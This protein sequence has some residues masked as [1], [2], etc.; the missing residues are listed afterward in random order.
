[1]IGV[2]EFPRRDPADFHIEGMAFPEIHGERVAAESFGDFLSGADVFSLGRSPVMFREFVG[3]NF[4]HGR[5]YWVRMGDSSLEGL[6]SPRRRRPAWPV[7]QR[8][9]S[10]GTSGSETKGVSGVAGGSC[11][12]LK[13]AVPSSTSSNMATYSV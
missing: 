8:Y 7:S 13:I 10:P 5:G 4:T 6:S 1:M 12:T 3:V 2:G 11:L 9:W